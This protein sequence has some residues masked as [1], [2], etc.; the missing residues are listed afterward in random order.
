MPLTNDDRTL[1]NEVLT[2][3]VR[4]EW[5]LETAGV[6]GGLARGED[7]L[8]HALDNNIEIDLVA[9]PVITKQFLA[10]VM[11]V[12]DEMERDAAPS[13]YKAEERLGRERRPDVILAMQHLKLRG[14][15]TDIIN[16]LANEGSRP[17]E[18]GSV[19]RDPYERERKQEA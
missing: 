8:R 14:Q 1:M 6:L 5:R 10:Q 4:L 16:R 15:Y 2:R 17:A 19:A 13:F 12:L 11:D 18:A 7:E 9:D 3:L